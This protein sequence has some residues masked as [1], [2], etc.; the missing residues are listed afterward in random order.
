MN[1]LLLG[2]VSAAFLQCSMVA[3]DTAKKLVEETKVTESIV[4]KLK[5]NFT[6]L[7]ICEWQAAVTKMK[8]LQF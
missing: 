5:L 1:K 4:A 2:A 8:M 6:Q 3:E 7:L